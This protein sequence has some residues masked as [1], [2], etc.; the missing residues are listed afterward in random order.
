LPPRSRSALTAAP[1]LPAASAQSSAASGRHRSPSCLRAIPGRE[2]WSAK[3]WRGEQTWFSTRAAL[4]VTSECGLLKLPDDMQVVFDS[5]RVL[6]EEVLAFWAFGYRRATLMQHQSNRVAGK[7][8]TIRALFHNLQPNTYSRFGR[9]TFQGGGCSAFAPMFPDISSTPLADCLC[10]Y[11]GAL[12]G[13]VSVP[14]FPQFH[15]DIGRIL[16]ETLHSGRPA[17]KGTYR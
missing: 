4:D 6:I 2:G 13:A 12:F 17:V 15:Q 8:C 11:K 10:G 9:T 14:P 3:T 16:P 1:P 5:P 7:V